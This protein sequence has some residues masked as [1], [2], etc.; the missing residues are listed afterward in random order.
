M[1]QLHQ[2]GLSFISQILS[3]TNR[4]GV[5][6]P[7][8]DYPEWWIGTWHDGDGGFDERGVRPQIGTAFLTQEMDGLT[9]KNGYEKAWDDV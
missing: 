7:I 2:Q 4:N 8:C 1:T 5:S 9:C 3:A 6:R